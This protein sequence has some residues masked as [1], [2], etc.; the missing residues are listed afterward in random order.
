MSSAGTFAN[1]LESDQARQNVRLDLVPNCLTLYLVF[2]KEFL[3]KVD[4]EKSQQTT[5]QI[6]KNYQVDNF[7]V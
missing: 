5:N 6:M 3:E 2:L 4:F 7:K 1:S